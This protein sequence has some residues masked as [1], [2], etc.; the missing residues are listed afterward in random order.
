MST[1]VDGGGGEWWDTLQ[2]ATK[3]NKMNILNEKFDFL[4]SKNVK[5]VR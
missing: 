5:L 2:G 3:E 4:R 1:D